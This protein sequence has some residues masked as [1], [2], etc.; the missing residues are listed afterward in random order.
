MFRRYCLMI[1]LLITIMWE[2]TRDS[3]GWCAAA[4]GRTVPAGGE[5]YKNVGFLA[6]SG[7]ESQNCQ[8]KAS[9][10]DRSSDRCTS[11]RRVRSRVI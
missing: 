3:M 10:P 4:R 7:Q 5:L 11:C 9:W 2:T 6:E 8:V 1:G